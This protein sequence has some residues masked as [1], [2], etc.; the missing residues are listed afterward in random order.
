MAFDLILR[1]ARI[2]G[3]EDR[4]VDIG[5]RDGRIAAIEPD[6]P[7]SWSRSASRRLPRGAGLRRNPHPSRQVAHLDRCT[8][9]AGTLQEAIAETARAK[10]GLHRG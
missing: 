3:R 1:A 2:A 10:A 7:G 6:A 5:I 4:L 9:V 8:I